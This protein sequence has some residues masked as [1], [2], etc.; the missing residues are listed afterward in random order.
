[1][2]VRGYRK[3]FDIEEA[4]RSVVIVGVPSGCRC[5]RPG[6]DG[7]RGNLSLNL[8]LFEVQLTKAG[9]RPSE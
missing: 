9:R 6:W 2:G 4:V 5:G 1:M 3:A 8:S 7:R